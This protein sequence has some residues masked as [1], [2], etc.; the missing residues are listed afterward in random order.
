MAAGEAL[1]QVREALERTLASGSARFEVSLINAR[2]RESPKGFL[3]TAREDGVFLALLFSSGALVMRLSKLGRRVRRE[4]AEAWKPGEAEGV[5]D[6][7][8][9]RAATDYGEYATLE[10]SGECWSGRSGRA[11]SELTP[12]RAHAFGPL[13]LLSALRGATEA[14]MDGEEVVAGLGCRRFAVTVDLARASG[15]SRFDLAVPSVSGFRQLT[16]LPLH[17]WIDQDHRFRRLSF[18]SGSSWHTVTF[19][20]FDVDLPADWTHLPTSRSSATA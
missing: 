15:S 10:A 20:A 5:V 16:Q 13:W 14:R 18:D 12:G 19:L 8:G 3:A 17:T 1:G 11:L 9:W 7:G 2:A 4:I 6:F